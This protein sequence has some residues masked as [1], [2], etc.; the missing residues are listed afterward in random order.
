MAG[1]A[2]DLKNSRPRRGDFLVCPADPP[3]VSHFAVDV[4]ARLVVLER[5]RRQLRAHHRVFL[6]HG[7]Y[8][9]EIRH[10]SDARMNWG[11]LYP[12]GNF[13]RGGAEVAKERRALVVNGSED[14]FV[15]LVKWK[16]HKV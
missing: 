8:S 15:Q 16:P 3:D 11:T 4:T 1:R 2:I 12:Y 14:G 13:H 5:P 7:D 10:R 6:A 9:E